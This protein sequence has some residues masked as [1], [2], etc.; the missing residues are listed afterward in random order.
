MILNN[1]GTRLVLIN[2]NKI[3]QIFNSNSKIH[4]SSC[5]VSISKWQ[6]SKL[7]WHIGEFDYFSPEV[8]I[9]D[10]LYVNC[11]WIDLQLRNG[12]PIRLFCV[13][14]SINIWTLES[15][16]NIALLL[17]IYNHLWSFMYIDSD[18]KDCCF[19]CFPRI[20]DVFP[21]GFSLNPGIHFL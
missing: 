16:G 7:N 19:L 20:V 9:Y 4:I 5:C 18:G 12:K 10:G 8:T 13:T 2:G 15:K 11:F 17:I 6:I 3:L 1:I 21:S 14:Y